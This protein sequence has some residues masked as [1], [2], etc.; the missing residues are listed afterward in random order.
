[1]RSARSGARPALLMVV[2]VAGCT[3]AQ[4][5]AKDGTTIESVQGEANPPL[6]TPGYGAWVKTGPRTFAVTFVQLLYNPDNS[7][8][9]FLK[10]S[11]TLTLDATGNGYDGTG[12]FALTTPG[13]EVTFS[14][15]AKSHG[16]RIAVE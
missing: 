12:R 2:V 1:M 16:E 5:G 13:G 6:S 14:G 3:L 4:A 8:V 15:E 7:V 10:V 9:G 11:Q